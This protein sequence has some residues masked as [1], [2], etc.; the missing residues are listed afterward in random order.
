MPSPPRP[1]ADAPPR[2]PDEAARARLAAEQ[3]ELVR[4]LVA[5][6][7]PPGRFDGARVSATAAALLRK[8]AGEV[9]RAWPALAAALGPDWPGAFL[10]WAKARPRPATGGALADGLAFATGL[11]DRVTGEA[12]VELLAARARLRSDADG[13]AWR[14]GPFVAA[15][16]APRRVVVV[17]R[18]PGGREHWLSLPLPGG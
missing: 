4:A 15:A 8:R 14:R 1:G 17:L 5:G 9:A 10:I 18:R 16:R 2:V 12:R 6:A 3:A 7:P 13:Y 11:G